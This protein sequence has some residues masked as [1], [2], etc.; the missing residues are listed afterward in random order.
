MSGRR[1]LQHTTNETEF[2]INDKKTAETRQLLH[3][4][5]DDHF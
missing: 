5:S 2:E 1:E 3:D 4:N